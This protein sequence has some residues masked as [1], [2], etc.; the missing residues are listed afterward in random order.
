[1][2]ALD[3][4]YAL[5]IV[6]LRR[7]TDVWGGPDGRRPS[8][9]TAAWNSA[10]AWS[11]A[12][13]PKRSRGRLVRGGRPVAPDGRAVDAAR[14]LLIGADRPDAVH[15]INETYAAALLQVAAELGLAVP[16]QLMVTAMGEGGAPGR[17]ALTRLALDTRRI[18]ATCAEMLID[19]LAG[20]ER[21]P[22]TVA[23]ELVLGETSRQGR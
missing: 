5:I 2:A 8:S 3:R 18:G 17:P 21:T 15:A 13:W 22:V 9:P 1:M 19:V 6:L 4:D 14:E 7:G 11:S 20:V 10:S 12:I 16:R 23:C